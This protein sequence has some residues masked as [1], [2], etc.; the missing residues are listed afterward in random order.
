MIAPPD[1]LDTL[2]AIDDAPARDRYLATHTFPADAHAL[3]HAAFLQT[4]YTDRLRSARLSDAGSILATL[5]NDDEA[6]ALAARAHGHLAHL[7]GNYAEASRHYE[8]AAALFASIA[9]EVELG[10]T[11][12]SSLQALIY[13]GRY[14][15]AEA[16]AARAETIF[17]RHGDVLRL[18]RLDSNVGNI[19]FRQDRP[20]EAL[21]RYQRAL[22]G[23]E[24]CGEPRDI[25]AAYSNLAVCSTNLGHFADALAN[26]VRAREF[27]AAHG[28]ASLVARADYNIAYLYYLRGDY[29]EARR[30]YALTR[31]QCALTGDA[32][33]AALCDLD[34]A[35]LYLELNLTREG[36]NLAL[37][38]ATAFEALKMPYEQAKAL[39]SIAIAANQRGDTKL[40]DVNLRHARRLFVAEHNRVWPALV[41]QLRAVLAFHGQRYERA[42]RLSAS[43]T[44]ALASATIPGR[45]AHSQILLARLWLRA[46]YADR[47]RA[48]SREALERLGAD[49]SPS[50]HFHAGLI[51]G[52]IH[53]TQGRW[54]QALASYEGAR[55]QLEHMRG[56]L[57]TEDLRIS[58][59]ADKLAVY[60]AIVSLR[61]DA[62]RTGESNSAAE[63][64]A[65]VQQAKSRSLADRLAASWRSAPTPPSGVS[66]IEELRK[67]LN[68]LYR[69]IDLATLL[70]RATA[71][72][73]RVTPLRQRAHSLEAELVEAAR[74]RSGAPSA[75]PDPDSLASIQSYLAP[76][77]ALLEYYE[78][79]GV[80]FLFVLTNTALHAIRLG[81]SAP[82]RQ[83]LKFLQFQLQK[84]RIRALAPPSH[85]AT[86]A[87][88][89][90]LYDALIRPA[91]E[92]ISSFRHLVIAPHKSLHGLPFAALNDGSSPLVDRFHLSFTPSAGVFARG[93]RRVSRAAGPPAVIAVPDARAPR[94]AEE[95]RLVAACLQ[96]DNLFIGP[97]ATLQTLR[98]F[99][100][101]RILHMAAHG[102]FRRDNPMFSAI[103]LADGQ[104]NLIDLNSIDLNVDLLTL[105]ACNTGSS[106]A[107][108]GDELLG[109]I[110]GC[111]AAGARSLLVTLWEIDDVT[112]TEF[113]RAFYG[114]VV[115][116]DT[117]ASA[118]STAM[119]HVRER[120]PHPYYWAPYALIGD[121]SPVPGMNP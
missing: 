19:Y 54:S 120:F 51:E 6:K 16:A 117:L 7:N 53:E 9:N 22:E 12:S 81:S 103:E 31:E 28:L 109:L 60:E 13:Q 64:F 45:A 87:H 98:R 49:S 107:I 8:L 35:E 20:A 62:P 76:H 78:A 48:S 101:A 34:E 1:W 47:A 80:L 106:V 39:V 105:S 71:N 18:A 50:V 52:E 38:A 59:L 43:A 93:R 70:D 67:D 114:R 57:D 75:T 23:F 40:A 94:I 15:D 112:A 121:P 84:L 27:C 118:V 58:I 119:R 5:S 37:A 2:A 32:Y 21:V 56:R 14:A 61:L 116:G 85:D 10:R 41:D 89:R 30:L 11:L 3:I 96:T 97:E 82:I 24:H 104:L 111:L 113:M 68:W 29:A 79:R 25:A 90:D 92:L 55:A 33:H 36:E 83:S 88:L 26:Y 4:L 99:G 74:L 86:S 65:C 73:D 63:S 69:Q 42:H 110:R 91:A 44:R 66:R 77:E 108:G 72:S 100:N 95:A 102:L 46:G 115:A 17:Q